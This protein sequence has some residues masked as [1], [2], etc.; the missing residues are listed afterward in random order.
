MQVSAKTGAGIERLMEQICTVIPRFVFSIDLSQV[1][2]LSVISVCESYNE[3]FPIF[4][5]K[6]VFGQVFMQYG[7]CDANSDQSLVISD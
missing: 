3:P 5:E 2:S 4:I 7:M 6:I 1:Y